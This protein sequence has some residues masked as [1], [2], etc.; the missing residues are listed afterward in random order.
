VIEGADGEP[1]TEAELNA[2]AALA[3]VFTEGFGFFAELLAPIG[4]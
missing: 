3:A 4:G 1:L 2:L